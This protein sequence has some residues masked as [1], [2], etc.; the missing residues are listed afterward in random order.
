LEVIAETKF[1][2]MHNDFQTNEINQFL[3][4]LFEQKSKKIYEIEHSRKY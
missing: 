1:V 4:E 2:K 3:I